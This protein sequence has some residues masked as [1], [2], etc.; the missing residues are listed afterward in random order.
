VCV[1]VCVCVECFECLCVCVC[2]RVCV[3]VCVCGGGAE[4]RYSDMCYIWSIYLYLHMW[5]GG[6][7]M[8]E[9]GICLL[10]RNFDLLILETLHEKRIVERKSLVPFGHL[11]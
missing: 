2:V 8:T 5:G 9:V 1:C 10:G 11:L 7:I 6:L 3:C 4:E